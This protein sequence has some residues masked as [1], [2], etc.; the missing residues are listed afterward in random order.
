MPSHPPFP[1]F[2][3]FCLLAALAGAGCGSASA[4]EQQ[5]AERP[6]P[7]VYV[8]P[9]RQQTVLYR[10]RTVGQLE[11][12]EAVEVRSE[13]KGV[14]DKV[15]VDDGDR[16]AA[17]DVLFRLEDTH[18]RAALAEAEARVREI[19]A[20]LVKAK[21]DL[22]QD[23]RLFHQGIID[24]KQV[25]ATQ[26]SYDGLQ[27]SLAAGEARVVQL[28]E[29][30]D[31]TVIKAPIAG[32]V[33][34]RLVSLGEYVEDGDLLLDL[35]R[36]DPLKLRFTVNEKAIN[37]V[38]LKDRV[39]FQV[40][41]YGDEVFHGSIYFIAPEADMTSRNV[42]VK[43]H[44]P[45]AEARL[46][47]GSFVKLQVI[48]DERPNAVVIPEGAVVLEGTN[49]SAYVYKQDGTVERRPIELGIRTD[50]GDFEV[51][52]GIAAGETVVERGQ[53]GLP[54]GAKVRIVEHG[55]AGQHAG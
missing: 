38:K 14:I 20:S 15:E 46:R 35:L 8:A 31:D 39:D 37:E 26:S 18:A 28:K 49:I 44:V 7:P 52:K 41:G 27:A 16:V 11:P 42:D 12:D 40:V 6:A 51:T 36:I 10:I 21:D 43:A 5:P 2:V 30:L 24:E 48:T 54:D 50:E 45:N 13:I 34:E 33:N 9:A 55:G 23:T 19:Q 1:R 47:P 53:H 4:R 32:E 25:R 22:D 29:D 17:G 3:S